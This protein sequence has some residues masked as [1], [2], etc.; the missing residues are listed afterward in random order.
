MPW[1]LKGIDVTIYSIFRTLGLRVFVR[2]MMDPKDHR[3]QSFDEN[4]QSRNPDKNFPPVFRIGDKFRKMK[5]DDSGGY[6][7][8]T[9]DEEEV[10]NPVQS[11]SLLQH[12]ILF[13]SCP[14]PFS[15]IP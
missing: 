3:L 1:C 14:N 15:G 5:F 4:R 8:R 2:P 7:M 12:F 6:D 10:C 13:V 9:E 11:Q